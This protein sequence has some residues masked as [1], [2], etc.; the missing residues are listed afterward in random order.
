MSIRSDNY[1]TQTSAKSKCKEIVL[2][3]LYPKVLVSKMPCVHPGDCQIMECVVP[4]DEWYSKLV[5]VLV[6]SSK[7]NRPD[8]EKLA[9]ADLDGDT[10]WVCWYQDLFKNFTPCNP[11]PSKAK[12]V[13]VG[14]G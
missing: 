1:Q 12:N 3:S 14:G 5:N 6:F 13:A 7:G 2:G 9:G 11:A 8:M 4:K 10:Y